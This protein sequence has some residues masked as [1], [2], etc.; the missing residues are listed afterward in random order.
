LNLNQEFS[1]LD[2]SLLFPDLPAWQN[3]DSYSPSMAEVLRQ[4]Y[5]HLRST[6]KCLDAFARVHHLLSAHLDDLMSARQRMHAYFLLGTACL[7]VEEW[8]LALEYLDEALE[9]ATLGLQDA[10][11]SA[12]LAY[13]HATA[14]LALMD[15]RGAADDLGDTLNILRALG[16]DVESHI[17]VFELTVLGRMAMAQFV[18]ADYDAAS[19]FLSEAEP[20][21]IFREQ[22]IAGAGTVE[23]IW[24]LIRR[25]Q[26]QAPLALQH[27]LVASGCYEVAD[28]PNSYGRI[29]AV[30]AE[31]ML[32]LAEYFGGGDAHHAY[33][34]MAAPYIHRAVA[35]AR[36]SYDPMG[37]CL[38]LLAR[39]RL[40]RLQSQNEDR[41]QTL[42]HL[43]KVGERAS[44]RAL[45]TQALTALGHEAASLGHISS[46]LGCY[47]KAVTTASESNIPAIGRWAE[48]AMLL[49][50]ESGP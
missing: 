1:M 3:A 39:T 48:R 4:A 24:A 19:R 41:T 17:R 9:I 42:E 18:L 46:A 6:P 50:L 28:A 33:L 8:C 11:A 35:L 36:E 45:V 32:D 37:E 16:E 26:G 22:N 12:Q 10:I 29:Q 38:A 15:Y 23:W 14:H 2:S 30:S 34:E 31:I 40:S 47:R 49:Y 44:D 13:L 43:I 5:R 7:A 25:W 27:A 20:L 21:L